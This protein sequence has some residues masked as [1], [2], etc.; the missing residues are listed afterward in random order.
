MNLQENIHRIKEVM[1]LCEQPRPMTD[2][3]IAAKEDF[4]NSQVQDVVW[5]IGPVRV[6]QK[7]GGIWFADT[8]EASENFVIT[9]S[10]QKQTATPYYINLQNP[11]FFDKF[12]RGYIEATSVPNGRENLMNTLLKQGYDGIIIG[13]D[14]WND[15]G[16]EYAVKGKQYVVFNEKN[17]KPA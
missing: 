15:S 3:E 1:G 9:M 8:K 16:D 13:E 14:W 17:V 5:R 2:D 12:W 6:S 4:S 7:G 11:Y 10:G